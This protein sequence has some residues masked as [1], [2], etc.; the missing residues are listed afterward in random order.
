MAE[1]EQLVGR[2]RH[3][4]EGVGDVISYRYRVLPTPGYEY[5]SSNILRLSGYDVEEFYA[6][7]FLWEKIVHPDDRDTLQRILEPDWGPVTV[8]WRSRDGRLR[9]AVQNVSLISGADG[10]LMAFEGMVY[11]VTERVEAERDRL[12][13]ALRL[14]DD[15]VQALAVARM[16]FDLEET[17]RLDRALGEA[18]EAARHLVAEVLGE[19][20]LEPGILRRAAVPPER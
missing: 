3:L 19:Q 8:R 16:A 14:H 9:W 13:R 10:K 5:I 12:D 4:I 1:D 15:V 17:D 2:L 7:P 11:D 18:L 6:D 20:V